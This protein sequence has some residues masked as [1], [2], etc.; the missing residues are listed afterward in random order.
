MQEWSIGNAT[1]KVLFAI[2]WYI[3]PL[4]EGCLL[5]HFVRAI[6]G[7]ASNGA[8]R[9]MHTRGGIHPSL[10]SEIILCAIPDMLSSDQ[11]LPSPPFSPAGPGQP[12]T[13]PITISCQHSVQAL[14]LGFRCH[15]YGLTLEI[16]TVA[17]DLVGLILDARSKDTLPWL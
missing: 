2:T 7:I 6:L 4:S 16:E 14:G 15:I 17:Y 13:R 1:K 8:Y 10:R 9:L 12:E 11:Y 5:P 3:N